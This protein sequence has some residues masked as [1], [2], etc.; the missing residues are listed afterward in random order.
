[1]IPESIL[2]SFEEE[3]NTLV[4]ADDPRKDFPQFKLE[5]STNPVKD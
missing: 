1:V 4:E 5:R 3:L 2:F